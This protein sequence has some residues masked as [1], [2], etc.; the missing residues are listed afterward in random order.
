MSTRNAQRLRG[1]IF[2]AGLFRRRRSPVSL[3]RPVRGRVRWKVCGGIVDAPGPFHVLHVCLHP[4]PHAADGL[5]QALSDR[6]QRIVPAGRDIGVDAACQQ[7]VPFKLPQG[8]GQHRL[9]D[10]ANALAEPGE[11]H[12]TLALERVDDEQTSICRRRAPG[13]PARALLSSTPRQA[14]SHREQAW[15]PDGEYRTRGCLL[16]K[17]NQPI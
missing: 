7:A 2:V 8:L 6:R 12:F 1:L 15:F 17:R 13:F 10:T 11:P 5:S 16:A 4:R 3:R 9:A 14:I